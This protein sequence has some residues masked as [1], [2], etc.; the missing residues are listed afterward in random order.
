[1]NIAVVNQKGG[2]GKTSFTVLLSLSLSSQGRVLAIDTDPQGGLSAFMNIEKKTG[3]YNMIMGQ[4]PEIE[5]VN[6]DSC[7]VDIIGADYRLD[8][9]FASTD[10]FSMKRALK[11][12]P[13]D[14][15]FVV[16]DTPPTVQGITRA[17][18]AVSDYIITPCDISRSTIGPTLY[19]ID[20]IAE[21]EKKT[22]PVLIGKEETGDRKE[23]EKKNYIRDLTREFVSVLGECKPGYIDK[24]T[25][26][27]QIVAGEKKLTES[28]KTK[29]LTAAGFQGGVLW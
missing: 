12:V 25:V 2:S 10:Q 4:A 20:S 18:I 3:T 22:H 7:S 26:I 13:A 16:F 23:G 17:A 27:Q 24:S 5:T 21:M 19:T 6:R 28:Y 14:Y 15:D 29:I 1:M 8:K 9:I 11:R